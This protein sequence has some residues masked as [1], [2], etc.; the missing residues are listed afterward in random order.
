M[1]ELRVF[2]R[3]NRQMMRLG[4]LKH[5]VKR[6]VATSTTSLD[7]LGN[8]LIDTLSRKVQVPLSESRVKYIRIRLYDRV[9]STLKKQANDWDSV[10]SEPK[11]VLMEIQDLYLSDPDI[12]SGVGK[13]V[14]A[15]W[16][17]YQPLGINLGFIRSGTYSA[18]T[19]ALSLLYFTP[20]EDQAAFKEYTSKINPLLINRY[21]S[22]LF[23]YAYLENDG[24]VIAPFWSRLL[25]SGMKQFNDR[26]AGDLLP[27]IYLSII[28]RH[29]KKFHSAEIRDRLNV[30]EKSAESI[31]KHRGKARYSGGSAREI[32][33][34]VRLEPFVDI[35]IFTKKEPLRYDF[36]FS[37]VGVTWAENLSRLQTTEE[38]EKFLANNFFGTAAKAWGLSA[39]KMSDINTIVQRLKIA[40]KSITSPG[41]YAPIEEMALVAGINTLVEEN[42]IIEQNN[43]REAIIAYQK[44]NPYEVRFTVDRL[45]KLAHA[46]FLD[47]AR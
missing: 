25:E 31:A 4:F 30:L 39:T 3:I 46:R 36:M 14:K 15:D 23:L 28:E 16:D 35:G 1:S 24:E 47:E 12:P 26:D 33:S 42:S 5:V 32:S 22:L 10:S 21:Q 43:A 29:R 9:Y 19:R 40:W 20:E 37:P 34:R 41:G 45:G 17:K 2:D 38:L 8:N 6:V 18:N 7:N 27:E 13:L 44:E 11:Y